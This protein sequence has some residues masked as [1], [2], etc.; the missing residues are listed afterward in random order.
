M[1]FRSVAFTSSVEAP[2]DMP[3][4]DFR[5]AFEGMAAACHEFG[6]PNAG[7]NIK[8]GPRFCCHGTA[9]GAVPSGSALTRRGCRPGDAIVAIGECGRF[10]ACYLMARRAGLS[11]LPESEKAR[12]LRPKPQLRAMT[13]LRKAGVVSASSD[14]SDGILG[15]A[16]NI[17]E[18]S[19]CTIEFDMK[20]ELV[21][22]A[23]RETAHVEG[24]DPWNLMFMWGDW[25]VLISV[26]KE[27]LAKFVRLTSRNHVP[28]LLLGRAG[29]GEPTLFGIRDGRRRPLNLL[30]NENFASS[31]FNSSVAEHLEYMLRGNLF[32]DA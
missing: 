3:V 25:Q 11:S 7:G 21:S 13:S 28:S 31:A 4:S 5:S 30:R 26:P 8:T 24:A 14:N 32:A 10:I 6:I 23:V 27:S 9:I 22:D 20:D 19:G 16:W 17:A 1:L 29:Q 15:A 12:L 2:D 18:A